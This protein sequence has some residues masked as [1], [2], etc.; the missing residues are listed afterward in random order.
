MYL[1]FYFS[2]DGFPE[3]E[4]AAQKTYI[5]LTLIDTARLLSKMAVH[6]T[7]SYH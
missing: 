6:F 4:Y 1:F 2:R 5:F 7:F 3:E